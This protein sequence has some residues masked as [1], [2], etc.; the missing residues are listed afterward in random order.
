MKAMVL[1]AGRGERMLP[2]T[3]HTPKPLLQV[4]GRPLIDYHLH[5]LARAG[6]QEVVVNVAHLGEQIQAHCGDGSAYGLR[7]QWSVEPQPLETAGGILHALPL[8]GSA[9]FLVVN[10]D[11]WMD[12]PVA[13]LC[14]IAAALAPGAAHLL[15]V[16]NPEHHPRGD[17]ALDAATGRV[18]SRIDTG[19][20]LTFAGVGV[21]HPAFF[22]GS[23]PASLPLLPLLLRALGAG[24]LYGTQFQG[25][26]QDIGTPERLQK[27]RC[28]LGGY[29]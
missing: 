8:L 29:H 15:L 14:A 3:A 20:N 24:L 10:A 27:L 17:F 4:G 13:Q 6:V 5:R 16:P 22:A 21:Y 18:L 9:P 2:L 11:I 12:Y 28:R 19:R 26:W 7:I 25:E 1:A 23:H